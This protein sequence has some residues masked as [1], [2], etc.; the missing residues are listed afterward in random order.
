[1]ANVV[2][3]DADFLEKEKEVGPDGMVELGEW[4]RGKSVTLVAKSEEDR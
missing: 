3:D 4:F 1:M 2:I